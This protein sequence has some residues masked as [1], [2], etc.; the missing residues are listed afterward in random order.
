MTVGV[1]RLRPRALQ[2]AGR[3]VSG[4]K[5]FDVLAR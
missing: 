1:L 5:L 2:A 4:W 3:L